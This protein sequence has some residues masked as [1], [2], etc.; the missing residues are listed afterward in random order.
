MDWKQKKIYQWSAQ[1]SPYKNMDWEIMN[2][3]HIFSFI[4]KSKY[5]NVY[6]YKMLPTFL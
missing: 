1:N 4:M 3:E 5:K 2:S 6:S